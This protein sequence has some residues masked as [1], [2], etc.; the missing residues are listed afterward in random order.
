MKSFQK[1]RFANF[2]FLHI[3]NVMEGVFPFLTTV[4]WT[5]FASW[6]TRRWR[7]ALSWFAILVAR[8]KTCLKIEYSFRWHTNNQSY[9]F[10]HSI[11]LDCASSFNERCK[12]GCEC[13]KKGARWC[14]IKTINR[15]C[16]NDKMFTSFVCCD[17]KLKTKKAKRQMNRRLNYIGFF[18]KLC[19]SLLLKVGLYSGDVFGLFCMN[20]WKVILGSFLLINWS[21]LFFSAK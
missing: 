13:L 4:K 7:S 5:L 10:L 1:S 6:K 8:R 21:F 20:L 9:F 2:A 14:H 11:V 18:F 3:W 17:F 19:S 15:L 16:S 12:L